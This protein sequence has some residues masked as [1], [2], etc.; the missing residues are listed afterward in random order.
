MLTVDKSNLG[1][2]KDRPLLDQVWAN[3]SAEMRGE[4]QVHSSIGLTGLASG[5]KTKLFSIFG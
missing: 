3:V 5:L 1:G 2:A 4:P